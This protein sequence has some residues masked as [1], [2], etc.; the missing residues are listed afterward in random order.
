M[1]LQAQCPSLHLSSFLSVNLA[2]GKVQCLHSP[3]ET[4]PWS[5][6]FTLLILLSHQPIPQVLT[7]KGGLT[8]SLMTI[9]VAH[10]ATFHFS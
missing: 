5:P 7:A 9:S 1:P 10:R 4:L 2:K 8:K 3:G 6:A